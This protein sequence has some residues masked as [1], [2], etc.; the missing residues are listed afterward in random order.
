MQSLI[1]ERSSELTAATATPRS[2]LD[3]PEAAQIRQLI[4]VAESNYGTAAKPDSSAPRPLELPAPEANSA[5]E[6]EL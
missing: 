1:I 6:I 3:Q 5:P 2:E 4:D